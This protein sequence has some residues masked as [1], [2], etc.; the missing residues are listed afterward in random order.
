MLTASWPGLLTSAH[1][2]IGISRGVPRRQ[3][4]GFGMCRKLAPGPWF[5]SVS[6]TEYAQL[7]R[8]EV[9]SRLDPVAVAAELGKMAGE[10]IPVLVCFEKPGRGDW[11]HRAMAAQWLA[12][13]IGEPVPELGFEHLPLDQHPLLPLELRLAG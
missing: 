8:E 11:C 5:N 12:D 4:A 3:A 10:R 6:P 2:R 1:L 13:G 9:L 7:Y